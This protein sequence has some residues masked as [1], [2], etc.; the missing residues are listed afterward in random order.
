MFDDLLHLTRTQSHPGKTMGLPVCLVTVALCMLTINSNV[1]S[2][3]AE[4]MAKPPPDSDVAVKES[5]SKKNKISQEFDPFLNS[6]DLSAPWRGSQVV[7]RNSFSINSLDRSAELTYNP[8]YAM[9]WSFRPRWWF[10]D[11][12][13]VRAGIDITRELT[14]AD[15]TTY[16]GEAVIGDLALVG[17]ISKFL[18]VPWVGIDFSADLVITMP[19]SKVS[20]SRT[21]NF[22]VGPGLR[23]S[24]TF[25]LLRALIIGYNLRVSLYSHRNTTSE[26]ETPLITGCMATEGGC[27]AFLNTGVRNPVL[28]LVQV[29]DVTLVVLDW[30]GVGIS[31]GHVIDWLYTF[32]D[33]DPRVSYQ[34]QESTNQRYLSVF[35]VEAFFNPIDSLEIGVGYSTVNPQ[36]APD[37]TYYNP[38]YNRYSRVYID[39]RLRI[40]GLVSQIVGK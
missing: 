37:S 9:S 24:K 22:G 28:R 1:L 10:D 36:L 23:L 18:S 4:P 12:V 34:P 2:E 14:E 6:A 5:S 31:F 30:F 8:Y 17:G 13:F 3:E 7:F 40:D 11:H 25:N 32:E 21:L 19:T 38:F 29:A 16:S 35:E 26:R 15:E 33:D 39:L 27:D 20:Q